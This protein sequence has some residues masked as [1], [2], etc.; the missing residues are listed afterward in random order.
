MFSGHWNVNV[1]YIFLTEA[2]PN[3]VE[4]SNWIS[5]WLAQESKTCLTRNLDWGLWVQCPYF[6]QAPDLLSLWDFCCPCSHWLGLCH[7]GPSLFYQPLPLPFCPSVLS[8]HPC[9]LTLYC[10]NCCCLSSHVK[11]SLDTPCHGFYIIDLFNVCVNV[12]QFHVAVGRQLVGIAS[13]RQMSLRDGTQHL[14][15]EG[16]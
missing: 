5:L 8:V 15:L 2:P 3:K 11:T 4:Y 16:K 13:L 9:G 10:S 7:R 1:S 12:S 14:R 6:F